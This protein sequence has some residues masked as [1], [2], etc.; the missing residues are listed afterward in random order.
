MP[1]VFDCKNY[2]GEP[3][4]IPTESTDRLTAI[5]QSSQSTAE[6]KKQSAELLAW[7]AE[8]IERAS[9]LSALEQAAARVLVEF[10]L[11]W[12]LDGTHRL[13]TKTVNGQKQRVLETVEAVSVA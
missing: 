7:A 8:R 12:I 3:I 11:S 6:Q 1:K 13:V 10:E 2:L 4:V 5:V 9:S